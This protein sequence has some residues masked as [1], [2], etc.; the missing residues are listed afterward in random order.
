MP[1]L[2]YTSFTWA[3]DGTP[4][5]AIGNSITTAF[6]TTGTHTVTVTATNRIGSN[7]ASAT[8]TVTECDHIT[9]FPYVQDFETADVYD[10]FTFIDADGDGYNWMTNYLFNQ[11]DEAGN[12]QGH[13]GSHGMAASASWNQ[14][15]GALTPDNLAER[16]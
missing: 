10:C 2:S 1:I 3:I 16:P 13:N 7:S 6:S 4:I 12:Y 9:S 11:T 14:T 15:D 5:D 8:I